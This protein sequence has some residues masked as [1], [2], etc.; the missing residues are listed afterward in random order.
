MKIA[1]SSGTFSSNKKP[2]LTLIPHE[3][4]EDIL[5]KCNSIAL[6]LCTDPADADSAKIKKNVCVLNGSESL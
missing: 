2:L 5:N 4:D 3:D 6:S 1:A